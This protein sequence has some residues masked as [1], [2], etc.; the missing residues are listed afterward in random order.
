MLKQTFLIVLGRVHY[1]QHRTT[2]LPN[3]SQWTLHFLRKIEGDRQVRTHISKNALDVRFVRPEIN[4]R[5][6]ALDSGTKNLCPP[7]TDGKHRD[8]E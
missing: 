3:K 7:P 1:S 2:C 5:L 4:R 6:F 8:H